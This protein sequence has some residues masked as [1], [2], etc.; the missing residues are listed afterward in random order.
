MA[1]KLESFIALRVILRK[2]DIGIAFK[3]AGIKF[4]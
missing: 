1:E 2:Q 4:R 3:G